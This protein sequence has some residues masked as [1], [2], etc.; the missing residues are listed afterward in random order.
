MTIHH[1][2]LGAVVESPFCQPLVDI[3]CIGMNPGSGGVEPLDQGVNRGLL[4][5][6]QHP[7]L[8]SRA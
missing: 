1:L 2:A 3:V 8:D 4:D 5:V 6:V 7:P